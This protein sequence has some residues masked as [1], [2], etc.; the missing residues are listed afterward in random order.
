VPTQTGG[1]PAPKTRYEE[2]LLRLNWTLLPRTYLEIGVHSGGSIRLTTPSTDVVAV[3]PAP[4]LTFEPPARVQVFALTSDDFFAEHDPR[5]LLGGRPI[6]LAFIDGMHLFEYALRDFINAE[7]SMTTDG[8][9]VIDDCYP[10]DPAEAARE[11]HTDRWTGDVWKVITC[12]R[13]HRPDLD[14]RVIDVAPAGVGL[15]TGLD[16]TSTLLHDRYDEIVARY[17]EREYDEI[18]GQ[19]RQ[20]LDL[21]AYDW[22]AIERS[23][24]NVPL[25]RPTVDLRARRA[26]TLGRL[27]AKRWLPRGLRSRVSRL[28]SRPSSSPPVR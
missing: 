27:W 21:R 25:G 8:V 16:P 4:Q 24:P 7:R 5:E 18:V 15:V 23:L 3:D 12:L 14:V 28:R 17:V 11:R 2:L 20:L 6:D 9:I 1:P 22:R 26:A 13:E 19:E 10:A